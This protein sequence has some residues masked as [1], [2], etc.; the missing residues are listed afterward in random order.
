MA[1]IPP[2]VGFWSKLFVIQAIVDLG[3][4]GL[5]V[6]AVMSSL[7]G[8]FYYLRV[9]KIMYFDANEVPNST[10]TYRTGMAIFGV[11]GFLLLGL[12]L[13]PGWLLSLCETLIESSVRTF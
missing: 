6:L 7:V 12:G 13:F 5:A 9:V 8:A 10:V 4:V 11:N 2:T 3:Y 1:G